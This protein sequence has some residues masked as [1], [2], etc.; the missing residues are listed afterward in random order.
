M[1]FSLFFSF[2]QAQS[3]APES[4][5]WCT[6]PRHRLQLL[7]FIGICYLPVLLQYFHKYS[8]LR[9]TFQLFVSSTTQSQIGNIRHLFLLLSFHMYLLLEIRAA[10]LRLA[11]QASPPCGHTSCFT[12]H[13]PSSRT[14]AVAQGP[15]PHVQGPA[16][17]RGNL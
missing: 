8:L 4:Q 7:T 2:P 14:R 11:A 3:L 5:D 17:L 15:D 13:T 9:L 10:L 12:T 6:P 16:G 1:C